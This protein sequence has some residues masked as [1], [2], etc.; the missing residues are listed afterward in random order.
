[1]SSQRATLYLSI[2]KE[3]VVYGKYMKDKALQHHHVSY[4]E[5]E[6]ICLTVEDIFLL[7]LKIHLPSYI[8]F[9]TEADPV[10]L[11]FFRRKKRT[12]DYFLFI[13]ED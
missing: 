2:K 8:Q 7:F 9:I 3:S 4:I 6:I 10:I 13:L 5:I 12:K 1:M 11:W